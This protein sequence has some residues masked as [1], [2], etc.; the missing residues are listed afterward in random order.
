MRR[1]RSPKEW[2]RL[3]TVAVKRAGSTSRSVG[4]VDT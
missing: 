2:V 1:V 4:F 3:V